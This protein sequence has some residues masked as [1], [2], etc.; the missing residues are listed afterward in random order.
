MC[1]IKIIFAYTIKQ[2][3]IMKTIKANI[4]PLVAV[5]LV[6]AFVTM[7]II[8]IVHLTNAGLIHWNR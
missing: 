4:I 8:H 7:A 6:I 5:P 3:K 1:I 2:N